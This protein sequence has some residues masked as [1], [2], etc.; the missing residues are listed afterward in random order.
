MKIH[1]EGY[2]TII[3]TGAV[4]SLI[5]LFLHQKNVESIILYPLSLVFWHSL[6]LLL[7]FLETLN[8]CL[9]IIQMQL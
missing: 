2:S 5:L 8:E 9:H 3:F 7:V 6:Y 4:L 1:K